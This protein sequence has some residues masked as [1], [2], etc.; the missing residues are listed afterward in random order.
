MYFNG[1]LEI[2]PSQITI[3]KKVKPSKLFGKLKDVLSFGALGEKQEQETFTAVSILQQ[4]NMGLRSI[5]VK[6]VIRLA[7]DDY[8]FYLDE[9]GLDDDLEQAMFEFKAKVDPLES[10]LFDTIFLVLEH[11]N[12][13]LKYIIEIS[14]MRKHKV[15]E[16]PI[17]ININGVLKEFRYSNDNTAKNRIKA[18]IEEIFTDQKKYDAF[19]LEKKMLFDIFIDDL[20]QAI[21]KFIR[22]D[23]LIKQSNIQ[24]IRTKQKIESPKQIKHGRYAEPIHYGYYGIDDF[25]FYTTMWS[26]LMFTHNL[27]CAN[28][29]IVDG[30]GEPILRV[31]DNGFH[32]GESN[33]LNSG[34]PFE[35][36]P[37]GDIE[38]FG[39]NEFS[40]DLASANLLTTD[41][42]SDNDEVTKESGWLDSTTETDKG[43]CSSCS[44]CGSCT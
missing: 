39:N 28:C 18:K 7:V 30:L 20:A 26:S 33:T 6:N 17:K 3:F 24:I 9:K 31:G 10:E 5:N 2:D 1:I 35:A 16:Y 37:G 44:S 12:D 23:D 27:M 8:D 42:E 36:P 38:Y 21:K 25:F 14:V 40:N 32:A 19:V 11:E 22:V 43:A 29:L 41:D 13:Y 34:T 15:G 4:I